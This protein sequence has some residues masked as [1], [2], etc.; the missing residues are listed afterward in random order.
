MPRALTLLAELVRVAR[1]L[2]AVERGRRAEGPEPLVERLRAR[3]RGQ[4][5]RGPDARADL[6]RVIAAVDR[7]LPGEPS[8]YR[9]ALLEMG[10]D[11]GA[12]GEP[13]RMGLR[14][15][16]GPRSGHAWLG[17]GAGDPDAGGPYDVQLDM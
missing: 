1:M 9:R 17:G 8:C 16:G 15:P 2:P 5:R 4:A 13:L 11:A 10:L 3:G 6:R 7:C 14:V 12:A